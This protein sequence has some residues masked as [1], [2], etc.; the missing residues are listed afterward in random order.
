[1]HFVAVPYELPAEDLDCKGLAELY[2]EMWPAVNQ[3]A[4]TLYVQEGHTLT[5]PCTQVDGFVSADDQSI[6]YQTE[7]IAPDGRQLALLT[8]DRSH[9]T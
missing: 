6:Y 9:T 5:G 7:I 8:W 3:D 2:R 4:I 1:M